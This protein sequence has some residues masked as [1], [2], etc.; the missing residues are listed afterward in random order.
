MSIRDKD[1]KLAI[2]P[3]W[4]NEVSGRDWSMVET[5]DRVEI[6][7][8][9]YVNEAEF[10]AEAGTIANRYDATPA[11]MVEAI[12]ELRAVLACCECSPNYKAIKSAM[13]KTAKYE[14]TK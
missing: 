10:I 1:G 5:D 3:G 6:A 11:E 7:E 12:R 4:W 14:D 8:V 13:N 9:F 2:A